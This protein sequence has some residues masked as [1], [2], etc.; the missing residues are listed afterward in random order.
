MRSAARAISR[1]A[2]RG[3]TVSSNGLRRDS[4]GT[5]VLCPTAPYL[6]CGNCCAPAHQL[7]CSTVRLERAHER[8]CFFD[9]LAEY[10]WARDAAGLMPASIDQLVKPVIEV[11]EHYNVVPWQLTS[12]ALDRYFTG[13]GK[14]ARST[15]RAKINKI[16]AY[17]VFLEQRYA[18]EIHR[19][20][21]SVVESPVAP[22]NRPRHR[23]DF[24][25]RE[26]PSQRA[27][28]EFVPAWRNALP[29]ARKE[30]V[31]CMQGLRHGEDSRPVRGT[32]RGAVRCRTRGRALGV[33]ALGPVRGSGQGRAGVRAP[34]AGGVPV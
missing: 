23:G 5:P 3:T 32:G 31:A 1:S 9:T 12:A 13:P 17:F 8:S 6:A 16:D 18:G 25:L 28:R 22:F 34:A 14:R 7:T 26:P 24:G 29:Q 15:V 30:A 33:G 19:L 2:A 20:F 10:Q 21:G 4:L 11:C 27:M